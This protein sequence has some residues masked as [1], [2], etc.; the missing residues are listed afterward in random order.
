[1]SSSVETKA[2]RGRFITLEG[3]EGAGKST[4]ARLLAERLRAAGLS[5]LVTREPGGTPLAEAYRAAL[6]S[7]G[8]APL[9]PAA[10]ALVFCA[11]RLDHLQERIAPALGAGTS[12]ICDRFIDSTRVY[13]GSLGQLDPALIDGLERLVVGSLR[14]EL[15]L[16]LD[17]P[18]ATGLARAAARR[19]PD[20]RADRFERQPPSF[21]DALRQ[22]FLAIAAVEPARCRVVDADR[23]PGAV[24]ADIWDVVTWRL[25]PSLRPGP[26]TPQDE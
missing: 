13:Q 18:A 2:G 1:M 9:G 21:H 12:V 6:L 25:F 16:V 26:W 20:Q 19:L 17:L 15:T 10:E 22:A 24:A 5:V 8:L 4:Q 7:G 11:A 14:P 23:P 3:G